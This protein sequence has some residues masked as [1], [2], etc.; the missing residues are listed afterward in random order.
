[1]IAEV[2]IKLLP[3]AVTVRAALPAIAELGFTPLNTGPR[4]G[5]S[6]CHPTPL[7]LL[8]PSP[9]PR[10]RNKDRKERDFQRTS[11]I[12]FAPRGT[13]SLSITGPSP[14]DVNTTK[15]LCFNI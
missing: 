7:L 2:E 6:E 12:K 11:Q 4:F 8:Q 14:G 10:Q 15:A 13:K 1:M 3:D 9:K 5:G